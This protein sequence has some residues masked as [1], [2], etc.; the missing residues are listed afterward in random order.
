M[1][2]ITNV[3]NLL[4]AS[5]LLALAG[6]LRHLAATFASIDGNELLGWLQAVA[7]DAGLFA[8]AYSIRQRKAAR[9]STKPLWFGV[10]LFSGISIYG[11]LSYGLLAENGTLPAWI[12]VSRPY[13]LAG[14]LPVLVLFLSELLSDD[15]QH[16]AEIAQRE[17]RKAAKKAESDSKFPADLEVANAARF[18]NKEAKKQRLA[19]LYQQWPGGTVTEYA[20]L[21]GVSRATVRNYASELG[22]AIGTNG[23]VKQ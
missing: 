1:K 19:E 21:L 20:K 23:K 10:T 18:A 6:S 7:I 2:R 4:W 17:A 3:Q 9:R 12:A 16:A 15:R 8:L 5:L 14:S 11:N 13:I 22:L